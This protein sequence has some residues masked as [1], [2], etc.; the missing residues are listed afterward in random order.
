MGFFTNHCL[1]F[2]D[3]SEDVLQTELEV[4]RF[5]HLTELGILITPIFVVLSRAD[6]LVREAVLH[7]KA[8]PLATILFEHEDIIPTV[9]LLCSE[10]F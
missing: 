5:L 1:L 7:I 3:G 6:D 2:T 8:V 9:L 10:W 4:G